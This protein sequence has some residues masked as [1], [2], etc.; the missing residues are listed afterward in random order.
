MERADAS[1]SD[2]RDKNIGAYLRTSQLM[3][4]L[5]PKIATL[6]L[7]SEPSAL[8]FCDQRILINRFLSFTSSNTPITMAQR[9]TLRKRQPYN[10]S[11]NRRRVVKTPGGKLVVHHIKKL[12][13]SRYFRVGG[14][15][16]SGNRSGICS[17]RMGTRE[18]EGNGWRGDMLDSA[19]RGSMNSLPRNAVIVVLLLPG[20]ASSYLF[21]SFPLIGMPRSL[22]SVLGNVSPPLPSSYYHLV[23]PGYSRQPVTEEGS[24]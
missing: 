16:G 2:P 23:G 18:R 9:V 21:W 4:F 8:T 1:D 13:V 24:S 22:L 17:A 7:H 6:L 3:A 11:S 5:P 10:T 20:Y 15:L 14:R 12:A 19:N